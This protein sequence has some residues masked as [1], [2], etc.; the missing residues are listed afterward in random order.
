MIEVG[1]LPKEEAEAYIVRLMEQ[2][3]KK[4]KEAKD[5]EA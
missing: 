1:K 2:Y 3:R 5:E 4:K